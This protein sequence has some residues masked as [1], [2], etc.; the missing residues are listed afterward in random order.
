MLMTEK[1]FNVLR[2]K[3]G[4]LRK[5]QIDA[6]NDIVAA[7][8]ADKSITYAQAAYI[9]ATTWHETAR[10]MLPVVEYGQG[11]NRT[12]GTWYLDSLD[13]RYCFKDGKKQN[14]YLCEEYPYLYYGRGYVQLTWF[15]NYEKASNK[16]GVDLLN[17]PD[18]A[19]KKEYAI[20]IMLEGMKEGWFTG[21]KLSDYIYQSKKDYEG[22]RR[23][24]NGTDKAK[25]IAGYAD[26]F[27]Y[28]LRRP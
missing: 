11:K 8:D 26:T 2:E 1:G 7:I 21:G 25:L 9:L 28:A 12:Y 6:I 3:F 20:K 14:A 15:A 10:T 16:I 19:S 13:Q 5:S 22:A 18:L 24:I 27:E 17:N 23:I 4:K